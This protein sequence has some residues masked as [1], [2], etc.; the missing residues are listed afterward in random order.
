MQDKAGN[1]HRGLVKEIK[2]Q[3]VLMDFNH[4]LAGK[5]L[6]FSGEIVDI[7]EATAEELQ[8]GHVHDACGRGCNAGCDDKQDE[9]G[10]CEGE[11][12]QDNGQCGGCGC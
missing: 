7:R 1:R 6:Y 8:H 3:E 11:S 10:C 5:G 9:H 2:D 4:P 12:K